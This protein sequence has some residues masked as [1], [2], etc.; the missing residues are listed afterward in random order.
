[1]ATDVRPELKR[2]FLSTGYKDAV[3]NAFTFNKRLQLERHAR[4][5]FYDN[6]TNLI[7]RVCHLWRSPSERRKGHLPGQVYS[8][9]PRR[10]RLVN[11]P[12][13]L[14]NRDELNRHKGWLQFHQPLLNGLGIL[15][16]SFE[17]TVP[18]IA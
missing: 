14:P 4:I 17:Y 11:E 16:A 10:W 3:A 12:E 18:R 5:P 9:M 7:Q 15:N 6:Q 2:F 13:Q 8:Y 1:M